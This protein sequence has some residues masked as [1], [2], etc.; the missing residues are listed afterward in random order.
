MNLAV[1]LAVAT[2]GFLGAILRFRLTQGP[3]GFPWTTMGANVVGSFAMGLLLAGLEPTGV[4]RGLLITGFCG[5]L[6]TFSSFA[7]QI[8]ALAERRHLPQAI[9]YLLLTTV[10]AVLGGWAGILLGKLL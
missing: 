8:V 5:T 6:T 3:D 4:W 7:W 9:L 10:L 1:L 2:G